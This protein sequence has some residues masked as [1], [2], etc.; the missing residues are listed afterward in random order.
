[1][2]ATGAPEWAV[3]SG[4]WREGD[5][6]TPLRCRHR[7]RRHQ[8]HARLCECYNINRN[9]NTN[10]NTTP[11]RAARCGLLRRN[12]NTNS[13]SAHD[14]RTKQ[15]GRAKWLPGNNVIGVCPSQDDGDAPEV[16]VLTRRSVLPIVEDLDE[17]RASRYLPEPGQESRTPRASPTTRAP[18]HEHH[19][20]HVTNTVRVARAS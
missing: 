1:M 17:A 13:E 8:E 5:I 18:R 6:A 11:N 14:P 10:H 12:S 20:R 15:I 4:D 7:G 3:V 9:V 16:V 19:A 2:A